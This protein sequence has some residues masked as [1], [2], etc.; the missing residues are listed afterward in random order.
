MLNF[1][2]KIEDGAKWK[3]V[4]LT[5]P[6][7]ARGRLLTA[8]RRS[9]RTAERTMKKEAP[10]DTGRLR[11]TIKTKVKDG[12]TLFK[13]TEGWI[14][15]TVKYAEYVETGRKAGKFPPTKALEGWARRHGIPTYLVARAI[16]TKGIKPNP[17]VA[18]TKT[19]TANDIKSEFR[20]ALRDIALKIASRK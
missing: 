19:K 14:Y 16:A 12:G 6:R 11:S 4:F 15:P 13:S 17:F 1:K 3:A 8:M 20:Q 7:T 10:V 5:A 9:V 2:I 18:R